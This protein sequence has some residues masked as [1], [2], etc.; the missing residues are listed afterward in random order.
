[1]TA[2]LIDLYNQ[3][4]LNLFEDSNTSDF[5]ECFRDQ[6]KFNP[7]EKKSQFTLPSVVQSSVASKALPCQYTLDNQ[8][9]FVVKSTLAQIALYRR[10]HKKNYLK[11]VKLDKNTYALHLKY[12]SKQSKD[13]FVTPSTFLSTKSG[14]QSVYIIY[15]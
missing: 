8:S 11:L 2:K 12:S 1:M 6:K 7:Y 10:E 9:V 15:L 4:G 3:A 14:K 13:S 5:D